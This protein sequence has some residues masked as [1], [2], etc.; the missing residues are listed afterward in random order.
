LDKLSARLSTSDAANLITIANAMRTGR[1]PF[2]TR[3]AALK[4]A[5][6]VAAEEAHRFVEK[7]RGGTRPDGW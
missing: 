1:Q 4:L 5:L 2:V 3:S 7:D 6:K